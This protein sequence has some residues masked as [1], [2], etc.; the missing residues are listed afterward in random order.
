MM[1]G[2][3]ASAWTAL[4][5]L[6]ETTAT[7]ASL[8]KRMSRPAH[9]NCIGPRSLTQRR[10]ADKKIATLRRKQKS[11]P[12]L[13]LTGQISFRSA[14]VGGTFKL[15]GECSIRCNVSNSRHS[16][17]HSHHTPCELMREKSMTHSLSSAFC[18]ILILICVVATHIMMV[19]ATDRVI[20]QRW[21]TGIGCALS[22]AI[23]RLVH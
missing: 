4:A 12:S 14:K 13:S 19:N 16:R 22:P 9:D 21:M 15:F 1:F 3:A 10:L 5:K 11:R 20:S 17:Q 8:A 23:V 18:V 6:N 2:L 7:R